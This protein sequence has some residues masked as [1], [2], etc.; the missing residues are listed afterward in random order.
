MHSASSTSLHPSV[1]RL[2]YWSNSQSTVFL[3]KLDQRMQV[4]RQCTFSAFHFDLPAVLS[5]CSPF[6]TVTGAL[7]TRDMRNHPL[8]NTSNNFTTNACSTC[9][10]IS[11]DA[12]ACR[13]N[14]NTSTLLIA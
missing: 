11:H 6:G 5:N 8:R 12:L 9:S 1:F 2:L 4:E 10:A 7:A 13:N 3:F 14:C